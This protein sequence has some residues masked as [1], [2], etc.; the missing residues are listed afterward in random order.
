MAIRR[1]STTE[2]GAKSNKF[3]DQD[4]AQGAMEPISSQSLTNAVVHG[5]SN[6]PQHY[7]DLMLVIS[8]TSN[9]DSA[10]VI[11]NVSG[12]ISFTGSA[13][14][15]GGTGSAAY[16]ARS[17]NF[18]NF[19]AFTTG[20]NAFLKA[21]VPTTLI[22]H[23]L[24]YKST[25][26]FK[27]ILGRCGSDANGSGFTWMV[28]GLIQNNAAITGFNISTQNGSNFLTGMSTLYGIKAGA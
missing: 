26:Q 13:T 12:G 11:D 7:Q 4:T 10:L 27:T 16:S 9:N 6:I 8:A 28:T 23:F 3:W 5:Y 1:F 19:V 25:T 15:L 14:W 2:F 22:I 21:G 18:S 20:A 17:T 24:N